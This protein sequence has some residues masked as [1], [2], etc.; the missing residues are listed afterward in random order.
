MELQPQVPGGMGSWAIALSV[1]S[2]VLPCHKFAKINVLG[3]ARNN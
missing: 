3:A 2:L 1:Q